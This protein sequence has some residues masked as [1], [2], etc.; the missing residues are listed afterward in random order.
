MQGI[1]SEKEKA[2][3]PIKDPDVFRDLVRTQTTQVLY[4]QMPAIMNMI[5]AEVFLEAL[6]HQE[7]VYTK[8]WNAMTPIFDITESICTRMHGG[9]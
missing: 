8:I 2:R 7:E 5:R 9:S 6:N 3:Q 1:V 4:D